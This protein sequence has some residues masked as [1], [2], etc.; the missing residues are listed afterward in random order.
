MKLNKRPLR[1]HL[2]CFVLAGV[3]GLLPFFKSVEDPEA[4]MQRFVTMFKAQDAEAIHKIISPEVVGQTELSVKDV[5][6]FVKRYRSDTLKL[7]R[8]QIDKRF[9]SEDGEAERFQATLLFRGPV[10]APQY[11]TPSLL[12]MT[13]LWLL[14]EG[15]WWLERPLTIHYVVTVNDP[16]PT[17]EQQETAMRFQASLEI[18][19][20]L[21][22]PGSEDLELLPSPSPGSAAEGYKELEKL[23]A[24]ERSAKGVDPEGR[25]VQVFLEASTRKQG[26]FL[27]MYQADFE[28]DSSKGRKPPPWD[29]FRDYVDASVKLA[30]SF[31]KQKKYKRAESVYRKLIT[32]GR[33]WLDEPGGYQFVSWGLTFQKRGAE[34]LARLLSE[35]GGAQHDRIAAFASLTSRRLDLL[36]SAL[37]CL[38]DMTDYRALQAATIAVEPSP[39]SV[40]KSWA[41]STLAILALKGAPATPEVIQTAGAMVVVDNAA[42]RQVAWKTL[43]KLAAE[44]S[45]RMAAFIDK[46]KTWITDHSVYGTVQS[47]R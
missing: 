22:F 30:K 33:Q 23:H 34:E 35:T 12:S 19:G 43:E 8:L 20:K 25:G 28:N 36:Q 16:Y 46:Q 47:F 26:G 3:A 14:E 39:V 37:S 10:L 9:K 11:K 24:Q 1:G 44:P 18:L 17:T 13:F 45:G 6:A 41:V 38:D 42:M 7:E 27:S 40:L 29:M 4:V 2:C 15:K 31:E 5:E 21:G 32:F